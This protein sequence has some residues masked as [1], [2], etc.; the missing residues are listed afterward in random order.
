MGTGN[1]DRTDEKLIAGESSRMP[2]RMSFEVTDSLEDGEAD[3]VAPPYRK[4]AIKILTVVCLFLLLVILLEIY[5]KEAV[6]R[7]SKRL[8]DTI[9]LPGLYLFVLIADGLPQP[10]TYVPLIFCAVKAHVPKPVVFG[11]CAAGSYSAALL[12]YGMGAS[13]RRLQCGE[14]V[15]QRLTEHSPW[16]PGLMQRK[17]AIGVGTAA[18]LPIPLA[19][20]TWTAGFHQIDFGRFLLA[21]MFRMPKILLFVL[22]SGAPIGGGPQ[23]PEVDRPV[24]IM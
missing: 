21:G 23:D 10:F 22:L 9:G 1:D 6:S 2:E 13:L 14:Q 7:F 12:G 24:L 3:A 18:L 5:A 4:F 11:V 17:G 19:L 8:M 16:L 20:A 15:F